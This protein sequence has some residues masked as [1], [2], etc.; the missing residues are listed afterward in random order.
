M[1]LPKSMRLLAGAG[2]IALLAACSGGLIQGSARSQQPLNSTTV[3]ALRTMGSSPQAG[4]VVRIFKE[5][6]VLEVWKEKSDGT[7]GLFRSYD[8]CAYSG[9]YGP[10]IA[11]GDRQAPEG[12]YTI[13]PG[14]MNPNSNYY[15]AF[16][17]GY[18]NKFDRAHGRTGANLMVHGA[19]SSRGCYSM[20]D[21]S[22]AEI[23]ALARESLAGGNRSFQV[24]AFPFRMTGENLALY[25]D[26]DNLAFWR[27]IKVGYDHFEVTHRPPQWDVCGGEYVFDARAESGQPL[28][29]RAACPALVRDSNIESLVAAKEAQ[30]NR[31]FEAK[32]A[33]L[34]D[35][36][37]RQV[38][39]AQ[40]QAEQQAAAQARDAAV[41]ETMDN[42]GESVGGFFGSLFGIQSQPST[43][44]ELVNPPAQTVDA[45]QA[46]QPQ[47]PPANRS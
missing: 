22:I 7:Y 39:Q 34:E 40:R 17:T 43:P 44:T 12:F 41:K 26:S 5:E 18:P 33:S 8:I 9:E 38:E 6:K 46:P 1:K 37:Q 32:V 20:T 24:Q 2:L 28:D 15:L 42:I 11:E 14:L 25:H 4:M 23:Y 13:T 3:A 19:C 16:N 10:K 31:A 45:S 21:E 35:A 36:Q 27:N 47:E 29:A 30:D